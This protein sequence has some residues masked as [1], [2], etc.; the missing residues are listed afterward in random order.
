MMDHKRDSDHPSKKK[1]NQHDCQKSKYWYVH[2]TL[3]QTSNDVINQQDIQRFICKTCQNHL[4]D[5]MNSSTIGN[6]SIQAILYVNT[7]SQTHAEEAATREHYV[8]SDMTNS[9]CLLQMWRML[10][11]VWQHQSPP[12]GTQIFPY[13]PP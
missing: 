4:M 10:H 13:F 11:Q 1:C 9:L 8:G 12:C 7:F 3:M 2:K 5:K 6:L